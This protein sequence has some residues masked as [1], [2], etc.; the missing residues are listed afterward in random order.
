MQK[1][2]VLVNIVQNKQRGALMFSDVLETQQPQQPGRPQQATQGNSVAV[3]LTD[4]KEAATYE[5]G[6]TYNITIEK[7]K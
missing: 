2:M 6:E 1:K 3:Q 7:D 4:P 5:I